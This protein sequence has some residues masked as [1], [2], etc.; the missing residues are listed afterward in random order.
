MS[1]FCVHQKFYKFAP[2]DQ[3]EVIDIIQHGPKTGYYL[4]G[5]IK[6]VLITK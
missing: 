6:L 1:H 2:I 4:K 5:I 3:I